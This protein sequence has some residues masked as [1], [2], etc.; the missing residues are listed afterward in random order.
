[1]NFTKKKPTFGLKLTVSCVVSLMV[2][3]DLLR[4]VSFKLS[5]VRF[6]V[7]SVVSGWMLL[8]SE[9]DFN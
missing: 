4:F 8:W 7:S 1:M 6:V 3:G 5:T 9:G 2:L